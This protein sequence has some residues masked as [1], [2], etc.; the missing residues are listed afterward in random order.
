MAEQ[1]QIISSD[2]NSKQLY[3]K[4]ISETYKYFFPRGLFNDVLRIRDDP[5]KRKE[6]VRVCVSALQL[7]D[8]S[9]SD[10]TGPFGAQLSPQMG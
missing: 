1:T 8:G 4:S 9:D 5:Q 3:V 2:W 6:I 10:R 7:T